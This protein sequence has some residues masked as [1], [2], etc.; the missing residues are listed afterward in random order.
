M[1]H[2]IPLVL[3]GCILL[4]TPA[5]AQIKT[6]P[7]LQ[8]RTPAPLPPPPQPPIINGPGRQAPPPGVAKTTP[9]NTHGDRVTRCTH[10]G[11]VNGLH[12]GRLSSYVLR[13][14]NSG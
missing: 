9:L 12:G 2:G 10:Q 3:V 4:A 5:D 6:F 7:E 14:G 8:G 1:A 13:C 11:A